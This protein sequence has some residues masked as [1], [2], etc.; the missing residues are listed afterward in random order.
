MGKREARQFTGRRNAAQRRVD[1]AAGVSAD[2]R[3]ARVSSPPSTLCE[4]RSCAKI[5]PTASLQSRASLLVERQSVERRLTNAKTEVSDTIAAAIVVAA[6]VVAA[7]VVAAIVVAAIVVAAIVAAAIVAAIDNRRLLSIAECAPSS[8]ARNASSTRRSRVDG[9]RCTKRLAAVCNRRS[10]DSRLQYAP[11][12]EAMRAAGATL[13][14][15]AVYETSASSA[16]ES[17]ED[18]VADVSIRTANL[19]SSRRSSSVIAANSSE[20]KAFNLAPH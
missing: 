11:L 18:D 10:A 1:R 7:I 8:I 17:D 16:V 5:S 14:S 20:M 12:L 13:D 19:R 15:C 4:L 2:R 6:I 3:G 9:R